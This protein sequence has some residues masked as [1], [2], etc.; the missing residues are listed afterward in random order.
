VEDV[1]NSKDPS[2]FLNDDLD[3]FSD[4]DLLGG[5]E[6][7]E[8]VLAQISLLTEFPSADHAIPHVPS[9]PAWLAEV[10]GLAQRH[11][12]FASAQVMKIIP[13]LMNSPGRTENS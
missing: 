10:R 4:S 6:T 7:D 11:G 1:P 9:E 2:K 13:I 5:E 3:G 12:P 8:E